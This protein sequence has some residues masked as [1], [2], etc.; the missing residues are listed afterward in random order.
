MTTDD[1]SEC[2]DCAAYTDLG[3]KGNCALWESRGAMWPRV[4]PEF[5]CHRFRLNTKPLVL[6][7]MK[8]AQKRQM[9]R[10]RG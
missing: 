10:R 3:I 5:G 1:E 2:R 6:A 4:E 7:A 9:P 8:A